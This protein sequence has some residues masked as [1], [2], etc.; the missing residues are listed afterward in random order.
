[1]ITTAVFAILMVKGA[2]TWIATCG[3]GRC[4]K[5]YDN[6]FYSAD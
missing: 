1:M 3:T 2:N 5:V 6:V 4:A